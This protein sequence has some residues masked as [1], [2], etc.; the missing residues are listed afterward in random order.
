MKTIFKGFI[1]WKSQIFLLSTFCLMLF[2]NNIFSQPVTFD[3]T[4]GENGI[5]IIPASKGEINRFIFDKLGNIIAIGN[6][7][8]YGYPII[9]KTDAN[10]ILVK[11]FGFNGILDL[12]YERAEIY[13][14]KITDDNK[15]LLVGSF[16]S[17][18]MLMQF[19]ENGELDESFGNGGKINFNYSATGLLSFNITNS[20]FMLLAEY[21]HGFIYDWCSI[22]KYSYSGKVDEDFGSGEIGVSLTDN[23]TNYSIFSTS[24]KILSDR[25]FLIIGFNYQKNK[26]PKIAFCKLNENGQFVNDFADNGI[27]ISNI[28]YTT[29]SNE[30]ILDVLED[31]YGNL[32]FTGF[33][34]DNCFILKVLPNGVVDKT[35]GDNGFCFFNNKYPFT[36][37]EHTG[38][39]IL[40]HNDYYL[41]GWYDKI[42]CTNSDGIMNTNFNNL[43]VFYCQN[44]TFRDMKFQEAN[45]LILGG[46]SKGKFAM[47]R[48]NIPSEVSIKL[49]PDVI[50]SITIFP[51]PVKDYLNFSSKMK[52]TIMDILGRTLVTSE[53]ELQS[54]DVSHLKSGLYFINFTDNKVIPFIKE[55]N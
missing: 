5:T 41:T 24:I 55:N 21:N 49:Q 17:S 48:I 45:K 23:N 2:T 15:I 38:R 13:D 10:G 12:D 37:I 42:F 18:A 9:I 51:N 43:G 36:I 54:I 34:N 16:S 30:A 52:F 25:S 44:F 8:E 53:K 6:T 26:N 14:I 40:Q 29:D 11:N 39:N 19:N 27:F 31:N 47:T 50:H 22:S 20:N 32:F 4:F 46:S 3:H 1:S 35:F 28:T 33:C 7:T